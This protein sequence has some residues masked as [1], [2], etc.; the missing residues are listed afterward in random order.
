MNWYLKVLKQYVDFN[1]RARRKE[2]WMFTLFNI[3]FAIVAMIIDN[4]FGITMGEIPY[5]PIYIF[6]ALAMLFPSLG[7]TI[8][9]L[10]DIGKSG[11]MILIAFVPLIG[12]IWLIILL[13]TDSVPEENEYGQSPKDP[14]S[15][16]FINDES[17]SDT[18]I[19]IVVLWMSINRIIWTVI[20]RFID[21][22]HLSSTY[23]VV[24]KFTGLVWAIIPILLVMTVKDKSKRTFLF[25]L[26]GLYF[27]YSIYNIIVN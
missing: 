3:I 1:S 7:V 19:L 17:N 26:A 24:Q 27:V 15:G 9:R 18:L 20:P 6:Y 25:V 14:Q 23:M 11:W 16:N 22:Y 13:A 2:Y 21:D 5:G 8:R 10:H 4:I 12:S